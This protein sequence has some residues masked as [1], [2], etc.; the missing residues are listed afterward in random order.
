VFGA[1]DYA[2]SLGFRPHADFKRAA[3]HL[4]Q[5]DETSA[6]TFGDNGKVVYMYIPNWDSRSALLGIDISP[7]AGELSACSGVGGRGEVGVL[8]D[9]E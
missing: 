6:I 1:V 9:G 3:R 5:W 8:G 2:N 7:Q 4:G